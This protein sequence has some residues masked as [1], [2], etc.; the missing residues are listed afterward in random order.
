[1]LPKVLFLML[2]MMVVGN[3]QAQSNAKSYKINFNVNEFILDKQDLSILSQVVNQSKSVPY[4][5]VTLSAHTDND[6][7]NSYNLILSKKRAASVKAF[8]VKN[9][10]SANRIILKYHGENNPAIT[11]DNV[12]NKSA[13]RR[14][15][16][17]V[18]TFKFN[19]LSQMLKSAGGDYRQIFTINPTQSTTIKGK[20]GTTVVIPANSLIDE[21]GNTITS[22]VTITL[23]EFLSPG[24][25]LFQS[26]STQTIDGKQLETGGMLKVEAT[27]NNQQ[28][29]LK[30]GS[31]MKVSLPTKAVK[32]DMEVFTG[33]TNAKGIT[34]WQSTGKPFANNN[35]TK[36]QNYALEN[37]GFY[38]RVPAAP[39]LS[40]IKNKP[41][42]IIPSTEKQL[43]HFWS[44]LLL[45]QKQKNSRMEQHKKAIQERNKELMDNYLVEVKKLKIKYAKYVADSANYAN[46][47][48]AS[49]NAWVDEQV[50]LQ[51]TFLQLLKANYK[52]S[53]GLEN[54]IIFAEGHQ[55]LSRLELAGL[56]S[57]NTRYQHLINKHA[58]ALNNLE[59]MQKSGVV[60]AYERFGE[61]NFISCIDKYYLGK[62]SRFL[63]LATGKIA[64]A[65]QN[66]SAEVVQA[67]KT[68]LTDADLANAEQELTYN[69]YIEFMGTINC[70]RFT[71]TPPNQLVS[72]TVPCYK[73]AQVAF[74]IASQKSFLYATSHHGVHQVNIPKNTEYTVFVMRLQQLQPLFYTE[75][76]TAQTGTEIK[77][78]LQPTTLTQLRKE[79]QAL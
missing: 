49:Y 29:Q 50:K 9:G 75:T 76:G 27:A 35:P 63:T 45:T 70:D 60:S 58:K 33:K 68:P 31:T 77:P 8:L 6:A 21:K 46:M 28:L 36:A 1:M 74:Y 57:H 67:K 64:V 72:I 20:K 23:A 55:F 34:Q 14:V 3:I 30:K 4:A 42:L 43:F 15:E 7:N 62:S 22:P 16:I 59:T 78:N 41:H 38:F 13:N 73:D 39:H 12:T 17:T 24:D 19:N 2:L 79:F 56:T 69:A 48:S 25:A 37:I 40:I 54:L 61:G 47:Y 18:E 71:N 26:L 51:L 10:V 11:N 5:E 44:R 32:T 53:I 52:D 66:T 65:E